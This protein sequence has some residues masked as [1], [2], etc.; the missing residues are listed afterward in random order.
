MKKRKIIMGILAI[1]LC[2]GVVGCSG[3]DAK[4]IYEKGIDKQKDVE[5][6]TSKMTLVVDMEM[7]SGESAFAM[8]M[9]MEMTLDQLLKDKEVYGKGKIAVDALGSKDD[10]DIEMYGVEDGDTFMQ[11][12]K[13]GDEWT[14]LALESNAINDMMNLAAIF[15]GTKN[16]KYDGTGEVNK[17]KTD[18]VVVTI[19]GEQLSDLMGLASAMDSSAD[20]SGMLKGLD[21]E[22]EELKV[23]MEF[24]QDSGLPARMYMDMGDMLEELMKQALKTQDTSMFGDVE[25]NINE[26]SM[27]VEYLEYDHLK[28]IKLPADLEA[29]IK[30][31]DIG[32][33]DGTEN[34]QGQWSDFK[35]NYVGKT[36]ALPMAYND[37][38]AM[39]FDINSSLDKE[40]MVTA[41]ES[42][43]IDVVNGD[44]KMMTLTFNNEDGTM[45][46]PVVEC[47][48]TGVSVSS[49]DNGSGMD[50][51]LSGGVT[52]GMSEAELN[53]VYKEYSD[54]YDD[55]DG[56]VNYSYYTEDYQKYVNITLEDGVIIYF[57]SVVR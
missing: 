23:E 39:G 16:I 45:D 42:S 5:S 47:P 17:K 13:S 33:K 43:Y 12:S 44:G 4:A 38:V 53:D 29:Y 7:K 37:V 30:D 18:R 56:M 2:I 51:A 26:F 14:S 40:A 1:V 15:D 3:K 46:K 25:F 41:G 57:S 35:F 24:Y 34:P 55:G 9:D 52:L 10:T 31:A 36:Y 22:D 6:S 32:L 27:E 19:N 28:E 54:R 20:I 8:G 48:I 11:Y 21:L 49:Y 50:I